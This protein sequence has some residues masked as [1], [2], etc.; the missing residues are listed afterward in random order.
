MDIP[1]PSPP[2][3]P[4]AH[5]AELKKALAQAA[6]ESQ[7]RRGESG[8]TVAGATPGFY[9]IFQGREGI[10]LK[11]NSLDAQLPW[12]KQELAALGNTKVRMRVTLSYF[13][14]PNPARRGWRNRYRYA[15]HG[16]R[17]DVML[18]T[19]SVSEFR[20]RLNKMALAEDE[21]K[22]DTSSDAAKWNLGPHM[23]HRGSLHADTW[24]G[25]AIDLADRGAI[26]VYPVSGWW[27]DQAQRDR[28]A[29]GVRYALVVSI[30]A[31]EVDV[32]IWTP[33]AQQV[34]I[35]VEITIPGE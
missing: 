23:R 3:N 31:P 33:V 34:C 15:S 26:G 5:A 32:D 20:K 2:K 1:V 4:R 27:K 7:E 12:P 21:D 14:E 19:E 9:V 35:P 30:D 24:E 28:S 22:P 8:I 10:D 11:L 16:L 25:S 18:P 17:F 29:I 6:A 13:V